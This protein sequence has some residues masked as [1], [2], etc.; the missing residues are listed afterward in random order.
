MSGQGKG[1]FGTVPTQIVVKNAQ[2]QALNAAT[3]QAAFATSGSSGPVRQTTRPHVPNP[4]Y[5]QRKNRRAN[6][7]S[8]KNRRANRKTRRH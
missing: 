3:S 7:K 2:R 8:R 6:R 1:L 5:V 4:R